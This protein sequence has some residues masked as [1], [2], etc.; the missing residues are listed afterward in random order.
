MLLLDS[1]ATGQGLRWVWAQ[2]CQH[3]LRSAGSPPLL[4]RG[5]WF[6]AW[7]LLLVAVLT[8]ALGNGASVMATLW[9]AGGQPQPDAC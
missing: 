4:R 2:G 7:Y 9:I 5:V 3:G 8:E 1:A 6:P